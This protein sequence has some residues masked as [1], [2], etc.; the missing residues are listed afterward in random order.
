[1]GLCVKGE[2]KEHNLRELFWDLTVINRSHS[3][4]VV[5]QLPF[6]SLFKSNSHSHGYPLEVPMGMGFPWELPFPRTPLLRTDK[7]ML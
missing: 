6:P 5:F 3:L 4:A 2:N 1:M 7:V